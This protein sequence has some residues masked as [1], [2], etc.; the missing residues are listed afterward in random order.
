MIKKKNFNLVMENLWSGE[1]QE[2]QGKGFGWTLN[3]ISVLCF[4][5]LLSRAFFLQVVTG[6]Q[7]L[8]WAEG[9]RVE[10]RQLLSERGVIKDRFGEVLARNSLNGER[11]V[12][13]YPSGVAVAH[14]LGYVGEVSSEELEA[15]GGSCAGEVVGKM[16]IE[17]L[18]EKELRG[19]STQELVEVNAKGEEVRVIGKKEG[20]SGDTL[21]LTI[22]GELQKTIA[23]VLQEA[24][25]EKDYPIRGAVVVSKTNGEILALTSW[26]SFD[27][28]LFSGGA[29]TDAGEY[30]EASA[31]L[32]D[33]E[34]KPMFN[35]ALGGSFPPGS[36]FKLVSAVAGVEEGKI[37]ASTVVTDTGELKVGIYRYG[38]WYFDQYGKTEGS[39]DLVKALARSNDIFFYKVGEWVGVNKLEEWSRK[40]GLG[41]KSN[42]SWPGEVAGVVP[43]PK[44]KERRTGERWFLGN[45]YHLA[46]GQGDLLTTPLQ[47][48]RAT[49]ATI[50]GNLCD[51]KILIGKDSKCRE[52]DMET[53]TRELILKGMI[54]ACS[55][56][57]TAFPFF[58]F[59]PQVACKTG[60]AQ[61]GGE[62]T[63]PH[64][65]ISVVVPKI[66]DHNEYTLADYEQGVVITVLLEEAGEGSYEAG[67]VALK[68]A[69]FVAERGY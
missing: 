69:R 35:R 53:T 43:D 65:W 25:S 11:E 24:K 56:G 23:R 67:P 31:V 9:N 39:V 7:N 38:S 29:R 5:W 60:T 26:P 16:G 55:Q 1:K 32:M 20:L 36:I 10:K 33:T 49:Q 4:G 8:V 46:I 57:G 52:L 62:D 2:Y 47:M 45:T 42:L 66:N 68:I 15:C 37:D 22:D 41:Q 51:L 61:H 3:V 6:K 28:N 27:P 13:E 17:K 12:R 44:A 59:K 18:Y 48:N 50:T 30:Q 40:M 58:G 19:Q 21:E 63:K 14:L 64:A 54:A 34:N